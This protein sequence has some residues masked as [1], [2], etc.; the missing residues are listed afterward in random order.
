MSSFSS[1]MTDSKVSPYSTFLMSDSPTKQKFVMAAFVFNLGSATSSVIQ[2]HPVQ[3][4]G[5]S[6][7][8]GTSRLVVN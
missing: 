5:S 7:S 4:H 8:N 1:C 3:S 6:L 2:V